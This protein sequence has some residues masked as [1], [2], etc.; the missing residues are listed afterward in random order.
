MPGIY[1]LP[2]AVRATLPDIAFSVHVYAEQPAARRVRV[3]GTMLGEGDAI[4]GDLRISAITR[5]GVVLETH[6]QRFRMGLDESWQA[7]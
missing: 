6:G 7:H 4:S 3:N 2:A 5:H 1:S